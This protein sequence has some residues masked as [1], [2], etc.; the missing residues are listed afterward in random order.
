M[1]ATTALQAA[2]AAEHAAIHLLGFLGGVV[3]ASSQADLHALVRER[4]RR[5][6]GGR[7]FLTTTLRAAGERP[8]AA[9]PAYDLPELT[10]D[11]L[12]GD[13]Q[14]PAEGV[15]E[16]RRQGDLAEE[17]CARAYATLVASSTDD[18]RTWAVEALT[19]AARAQ[20][21]WGAQPS[22]FPGAPELL[23]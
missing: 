19:D 15:R 13:D 2:L 14:D 23:A 9:A 20:V 16:V 11:A 3:P 6:R 12:R 5:H 8:V 7:E 10:V 1:S 4:H 22:P 17:S 21:A 18:L